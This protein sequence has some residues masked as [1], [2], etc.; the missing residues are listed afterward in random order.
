MQFQS[1]RF[2]DQSHGFHFTVMLIKKNDVP[3]SLH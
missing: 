3:K 1:Y 2:S